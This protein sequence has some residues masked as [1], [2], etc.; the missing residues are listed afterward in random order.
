MISL[1]EHI[2]M[3]TEG[4]RSPLQ[5]ARGA[6]MA[7]IRAADAVADREFRRALRLHRLH[8]LTVA[9]HAKAIADSARA[10]ADLQRLERVP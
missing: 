1:L 8:D 3:E 4:E 9:R 2:Q 7:R 5:V 6:A 10:L